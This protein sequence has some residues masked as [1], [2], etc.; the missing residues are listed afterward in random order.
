MTSGFN[1]PGAQPSPIEIAIEPRSKA[2]QEKLGIALAKLAAE[3]PSFRVSTHQESGQTILK[4]TDERHLD[5]KVNILK[6]TYKVEVY[7]SAPQVA[8]REK[9]TRQVIKDYTYK[10][11]IGGSGQFARI[12][13]VCQPLPEGRGFVFENKAGGGGNIPNAYIP[14]VERGLESVLDCGV[15]SGFPV[16]DL[17]VTLIDGAYHD[18]D[19]STL[20]FDI[21]AR[22][23]LKEALRDAGPVLL[24][25]IMTVEVQTPEEHAGAVIGDLNSR[26]GQIQSQAVRDGTTCIKATAPLANL[27]G[28][29]SSLSSLSRGRAMFEM[30]FS[31]Y[32]PVPLPG[33]DEPFPPAIGMRA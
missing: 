7:V 20:A 28:Y 27:F 14:G 2:D 9:I 17:K 11:L 12:K 4:G 5:I 25:P 29:R 3:D 21:A 15:L 31:H 6:R 24:E 22:A 16:V 30:R 1:I 23:A 10:K 26:R 13:I 32:A 19:S 18:A 8:Y 33:D